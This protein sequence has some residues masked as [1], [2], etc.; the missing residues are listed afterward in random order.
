MGL[1][2]SYPTWSNDLACGCLVVY[3]LISHSMLYSDTLVTHTKVPY[4]SGF[5]AFREMEVYR[6]LLA[7][8]REAKPEYWP[9]L[10]LVDGQGRLHPRHCGSACMVGVEFDCPTIGI[11]KNMFCGPEFKLSDSVSEVKDGE[12]DVCWEMK[13]CKACFQSNLK[14]GIN[15]VLIQM[16]FLVDPH[17]SL[18]GGPCRSMVP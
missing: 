2:I 16:F 14:N 10:I 12:C 3:D 5:L 18:W 8:L 15:P 1:D 4:L 17:C 7:R 9:E 13:Q 11:G 6:S